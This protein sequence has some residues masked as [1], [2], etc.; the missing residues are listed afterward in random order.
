MLG[1]V[2]MMGLWGF[3]GREMKKSTLQEEQY[4]QYMGDISAAAAMVVLAKV[5][6]V[7]VIMGYPMLV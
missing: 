3:A 5:Q 1:M 6:G 7:P 2:E 4:I